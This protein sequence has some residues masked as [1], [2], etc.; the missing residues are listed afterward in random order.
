MR[1]LR[2]PAPSTSWLFSVDRRLGSATCRTIWIHG[3]V[4][5]PRLRLGLVR[6]AH[7]SG[8]KAE[9]WDAVLGASTQ[10]ESVRGER[11]TDKLTVPWFRSLGF[12]LSGLFAGIIVVIVA[13]NLATVP[14]LI[15]DAQRQAL[16]RHGEGVAASAEALFATAIELDAVE[17]GETAANAILKD[18]VVSRLEVYG[19]DGMWLTRQ[20]KQPVE[21]EVMSEVAVLGISGQP[22]GKIRVWLDETP[23]H[24]ARR[25][26]VWQA[27]LQTMTVLGIA[28]A[29]VFALVRWYLRPLQFLARTASHIARGEVGCPL[30]R[31]E[32][33]DEI[34]V[35]ERAFAHMQER[36]LRLSESAHKVEEGCLDPPG[37]GPGPLFERFEEMVGAL[38]EARQLEAAQRTQL[39]EAARLAESANEA[40]GRFLARVSH[41][42]R[43]PMNGVIGMA[44]LCLSDSSPG[45]PHHEDLTILRASADEMLHC[46]RELLDFARVDSGEYYPETGRVRLDTFLEEAVGPFRARAEA[47]GVDLSLEVEVGTEGRTDPRALGQIVRCLADNAVKFTEGGQI[48]VHAEVDDISQHLKLCV[49]DSGVGIPH[50]AKAN[51]FDAFEQVDGT[52]T[53]VHRGVGLGLALVSAL[54][55]TLDGAVTVSSEVGVGTRFLV[56]L[57]FPAGEPRSD[58]PE[59][60][61]DRADASLQV[62]LV[63]DERVNQMVLRRLLKAMGVSQVVLASNGQEAVEAWRKQSFDIIL[64]DCMMP[65]MDGYEATRTIRA[66]EEGDRRIPIVAVTANAMQGD[67]EKCLNAGMDD[68]LPK[69]VDRPTLEMTMDR[70]VR[71]HAS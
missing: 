19:P 32:R 54:V 49:E 21:S 68:H 42:L 11:P 17:A 53:R 15:L 55:R 14:S 52:S 18:G 10:L 6:S 31:F 47:K 66:E 29:F 50:A 69:P 64:M 36:L 2:S 57:P 71:G 4:S 37:L 22:L 40:K 43:T 30:N 1:R 8:P 9:P 35:A 62:L 24:A 45:Q 26:A 27:T 39:A 7:V 28:L 63:E 60:P 25:D 67:R 46:I 20:R 58:R 59:R 56:E 33:R 48:L 13:M 3:P 41:E 16:A 5:E 38:R 65:I 34:G 61:R 51:I 23:F 12:R 70:W 44:D